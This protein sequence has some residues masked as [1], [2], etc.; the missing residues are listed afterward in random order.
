MLHQ[1]RH[2]VYQAVPK[3]PVEA[4]V[5]ELAF[6]FNEVPE[7]IYANYILRAIDRMAREGNV[8]RRKAEIHVHEHVE[9]YLLEPEDCMDIV[10]VMK[11]A[12]MKSNGCRG[13]VVRLTDEPLCISHGVYTWFEHPNVVCFRPARYH[14]VFEVEFS[15]APT[16]DACEVDRILFDKYH[17]VVLAGV[18]AYLYGIAG[19]PW[20]NDQK[21]ASYTLAFQQGIQSASLET[22]A[23]GQRGMI[24]VKRPRVLY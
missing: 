14:D 4:F 7:E 15:V 13:A 17:D 16:F 11:C 1:Q 19:K 22:M 2:V 23:G 3:I 8:L 10:A 18:R 6:E 12:L 5:P 20:S 21:F 24:R 9:N